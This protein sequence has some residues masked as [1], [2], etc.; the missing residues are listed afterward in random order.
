M[1]VNSL[2]SK[3]PSGGVRIFAVMR[4]ANDVEC[5]GQPVT[6]GERDRI[7]VKEERC[8]LTHERG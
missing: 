8:P 5:D 7:K 3:L 4:R 2:E 1:P 6:D